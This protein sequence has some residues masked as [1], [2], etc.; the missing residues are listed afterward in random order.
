MKGDK[1]SYGASIH[2]STLTTLNVLITFWTLIWANKFL[3]YFHLCLK[4]LVSRFSP[5]PPIQL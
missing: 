3:L 1:G 5:M 2:A 4:T